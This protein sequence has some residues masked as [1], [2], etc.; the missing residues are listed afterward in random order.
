MKKKLTSKKNNQKT[1]KKMALNYEACYPEFFNR[2]KVFH[3]ASSKC[4]TFNGASIQKIKRREDLLPCRNFSCFRKLINSGVSMKDFRKENDIFLR[5]EYKNHFILQSLLELKDIL[6]RDILLNNCDVIGEIIKCENR[7][8][9][10]LLEI[11]G[12]F[13]IIKYNVLNRFV[14][15]RLDTNEFNSKENLDHLIKVIENLVD[16]GIPISILER[17]LQDVKKEK[18]QLTND[19]EEELNET[20]SEYDFGFEDYYE[21]E[22][23]DEKQIRNNYKP[24]VDTHEKVICLIKEFLSIVRVKDITMESK[25]RF[26]NRNKALKHQQEYNIKCL[27]EEDKNRFGPLSLLKYV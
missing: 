11:F 6:P 7:A 23:L 17:L 24:L 1:L 19:I 27:L 5:R 13:E 25:L 22:V 18:E 10:R 21:F 20:Q 9:D 12:T 15:R 4:E 2:E 16:R 14:M 8:F 26:H 3:L